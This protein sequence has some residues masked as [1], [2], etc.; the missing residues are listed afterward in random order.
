MTTLILIRGNAGSGK[1]TLATV[2]QQQLGENTLLLSQDLLRRTMLNAKDGTNTPTIPL[3][4]SLLDTGKTL[5]DTII[6]EGI[7]RSDWYA[8]VFD[9]IAE[10]F[11]DQLHAY[12]YDLP[13]E[14]TLRRHQTRAKAAEFGEEALRRWW[15]DKDYLTQIP[16]TLLPQNLSLEEAV[17]LV[18]AEVATTSL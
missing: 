12:Y 8:P 4:M 17:Q 11:S 3:L 10:Q 15:V 18:L 2:L 14:E 9:K 13:F 7:F 16:E 1:T 5:C 6:I